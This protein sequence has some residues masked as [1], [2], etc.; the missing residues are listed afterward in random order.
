[1]LELKVVVGGVGSTLC[2]HKFPFEALAA[3]PPL[4]LPSP[5][6]ARLLTAAAACFFCLESSACG[7]INFR[8]LHWLSSP[9]CLRAPLFVAVACH[10]TTRTVIFLISTPIVFAPADCP[11][12]TRSTLGRAQVRKR[13]RIP[14]S[15][16]GRWQRLLLL[17]HS[18]PASKRRRRLS[19][20]ELLQGPRRLPQ[21]RRQRWG[22]GCSRVTEERSERRGA[23]R[24][25][26]QHKQRKIGRLQMQIIGR[27]R[28]LPRWDTSSMRRE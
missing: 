6:P 3:P 22:G 1:M 9:P 14:R 25:R 17:A 12:R 26:R 20:G 19:D 18:S 4:P 11:I 28:K 16:R 8:M 13:R 21:S 2:Y 7:I 5:R 23:L 10:G 24:I 27:H 15:R